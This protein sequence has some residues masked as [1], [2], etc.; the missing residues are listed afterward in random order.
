MV[1]SGYSFV[2]VE[3]KV[4]KYN[5]TLNAR[6][7]R[8]PVSFVFPRVLMFPETKSRETSGLDPSGSD[9]KCIMKVLPKRFHLNGRS[10]GFCPQT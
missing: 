8:K 9:I 10:I 4:Q 7:L 3:V 5:K 6:S 2:A 1:R